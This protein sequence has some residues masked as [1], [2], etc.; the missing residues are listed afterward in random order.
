LRGNAQGVGF[1][2]LDLPRVQAC[3]RHRGARG[4]AFDYDEFLRHVGAHL[5][6]S[7]PEAEDITRTVFAAVRRRLPAKEQQD[8][9]SQL[10]WDLEQLWLLDRRGGLRAALK[11]ASIASVV[12]PALP[13]SSTS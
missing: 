7:G 4:E 9:A 5:D 1:D 10:P 13:I 12:P 11:P 8:V 3:A 6:V 2:A